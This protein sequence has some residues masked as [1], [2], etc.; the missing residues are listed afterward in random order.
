MYQLR[1]P[2]YPNVKEA[3]LPQFLEVIRVDSNLVINL[4]PDTYL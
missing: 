1:H 3:T 2:D 4:S